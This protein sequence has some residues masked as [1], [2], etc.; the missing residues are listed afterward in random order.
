MDC[1]RDP[2]A[3]GVGW[4]FFE[5]KRVEAEL[6]YGSCRGEEAPE[7]LVVVQV[8]QPVVGIAIAVGT[9]LQGDAKGRVCVWVD[10]LP[11]Q[12][13]EGKRRQVRQRDYSYTFAWNDTNSVLEMMPLSNSRAAMAWIHR[14]LTADRLEVKLQHHAPEVAMMTITIL[15]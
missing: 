6:A 9:T 15:R 2:V 1:R 4:S 3:L 5:Y 13:V 14:P 8:H 10:N 11:F 7:I 12:G